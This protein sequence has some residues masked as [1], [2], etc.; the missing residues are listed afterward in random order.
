MSDQIVVVIGDRLGKGQK[1]A[2]GIESAGG[3]AI[4]IPG[5]AADMKLG[6]VMN[7]ENA[8]LGLSFCGSGGAG[9][10]MASNKYGYKSKHHLR[11][12]DSGVT[13]LKEGAKVLGFGFLD[14]EE[15]GRRIVEEYIRLHKKG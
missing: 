12:V 6:D 3:K 1:V 5:M 2:K 11:S 4:V 14:S 8:D 9:A 7:E 13:A 10:L 15:L